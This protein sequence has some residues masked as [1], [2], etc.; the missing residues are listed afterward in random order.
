MDCN[1]KPEPML[2]DDMMEHALFQINQNRRGVCSDRQGS[3]GI[4]YVG[5]G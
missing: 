3:P 2:F 1:Y 5:L 4:T